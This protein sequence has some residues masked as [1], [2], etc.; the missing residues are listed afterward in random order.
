[1]AEVMKNRIFPTTAQIVLFLATV[2]PILP[3][4]SASFAQAQD[5]A[6]PLPQFAVV[7]IK[8]TELLGAK[9]VSNRPGGK[10]EA[11]LCSV[12]ELIQAAYDL[13]E[14]QIVGAPEWTGNEWYNVI[15]IP[16]EDAP[17]RK[18]EPPSPNTPINEEQRQMLQA[19]LRDRFGL[20][21]HTEKRIGPVFLLLQGNKKPK[22]TEAQD[23][24]KTPPWVGSSKGGMISGDGIAGRNISMDL[25]AKRLS[26]Y[27]GLP[28]YDRTG[29]KGSFYFDYS[30]A[31]SEIQSEE[32]YISSIISAVEAIGL[33]LKA[34]KEPIDVLV[35]DAVE[36]PMP[37]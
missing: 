5:K 11:T 6:S 13:R 17:A 26:R 7:S 16:P 9:G 30:Y 35:V 4:N 1:M 25:L 24:D 2:T 32:E 19:L 29:L 23:D 33:K 22:L 31:E 20:K 34:G 15:G 36:R 27:V 3:P 10:V 37:N 8:K 18:L 14:F 12:Q 21:V 28:V